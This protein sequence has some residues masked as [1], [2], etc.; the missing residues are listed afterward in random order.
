MST[1]NLITHLRHVGFAMPQ[2]QEQRDFYSKE[3][4]LVEVAE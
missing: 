2:L 1:Q 3:W 4:G